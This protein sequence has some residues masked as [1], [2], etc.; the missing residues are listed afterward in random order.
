MR[1]TTIFFLSHTNVTR[2]DHT[3]P[4]NHANRGNIRVDLE[5]YFE[6]EYDL[7]FDDDL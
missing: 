4:R 2:I 3:D 6:P 1:P 7:E 5:E